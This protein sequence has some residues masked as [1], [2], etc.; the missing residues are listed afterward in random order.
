[1]ADQQR[2]AMLREAAAKARG[3]EDVTLTVGAIS[4]EVSR[5]T[6]SRELR[7]VVSESTFDKKSGE[8]VRQEFTFPQ[9]KGKTST[10]V[11]LKG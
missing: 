5:L 10:L 3:G 2:L 8:L 6:T 4:R 7:G 9:G 1:M 11:F